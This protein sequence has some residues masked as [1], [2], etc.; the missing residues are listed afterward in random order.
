MSPYFILFLVGRSFSRILLPRFMSQSFLKKW[1]TCLPRLPGN[2]G[3]ASCL[4]DQYS[5][6]LGMFKVT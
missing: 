6:K 2:L 4:P 5:N 3:T 1:R